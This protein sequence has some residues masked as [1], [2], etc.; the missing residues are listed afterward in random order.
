[1][2]VSES[3]FSLYQYRIYPFETFEFYCSCRY[4]FCGV[5]DTQFVLPDALTSH[6]PPPVPSGDER[7]LGARHAA[8]PTGRAGRRAGHGGGGGAGGCGPVRGRGPPSPAEPVRLAGRTAGAAAGRDGRRAAA[9]G[10]P[11]PPAGAARRHQVSPE[12]RQVEIIRDRQRRTEAG[13]T[14]WT[15]TDKAGNSRVV[16]GKTA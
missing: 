16:Y 1:M 9:G 13:R 7:P 6:K 5:S 12:Q 10:L 8:V 2:H 11:L 4:V 3:N 15:E 14:R